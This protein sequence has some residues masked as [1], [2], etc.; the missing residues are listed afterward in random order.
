M[1]TTKI[2]KVVML[3]TTHDGTTAK[4]VCKIHLSEKLM[5]TSWMETALTN[6]QHLY[7]TNEDDIE[8]GETPSWCYNSIKNTWEQDIVYYQGTMPH[9]HFK[10]FKKIIAS[11]DPSL[12]LPGIPESFLKEFVASNGKIEDAVLEMYEDMLWLNPFENH[13]EVVI[14]KER[15]IKITTGCPFD[16]EDT[17]KPIVL[18]DNGNRIMEHLRDIKKELQDKVDKKYIDRSDDTNEDNIYDAIA[19]YRRNHPEK[20]VDKDQQL[21]SPAK[22]YWKSITDR[23]NVNSRPTSYAMEDFNAGVDFQKQQSANDAIEFAEFINKYDFHKSTTSTPNIA[24]WYT[25]SFN[26]LSFPNPEKGFYTSKELY[27]LWEQ[28]KNK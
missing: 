19:D 17:M 4:H 1:N 16:E 28:N 7:L 25:L 18:G 26:R 22:T 3:P 24:M 2:A 14:V 23:S 6:P 12:G 27:E 15:G 20:E 9:Y 21:E 5:W 10:G 8:K 11:T 13:D